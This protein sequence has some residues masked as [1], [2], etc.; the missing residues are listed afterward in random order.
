MKPSKHTVIGLMSGTSLDGL[1]LAACDFNRTNEHWS[2]SLLAAETL[3]YDTSLKTMLLEAYH[4]NDAKLADIDREFG[5][6]LGFQVNEFLRKNGLKPSLI[7]SHG[8]TVKHRPEAGI[9]YQIG[10]G[11]IL[12]NTCKITTVNNFRI[13]DVKKGGQGAPLVP[14][15]DQLLFAHYDICLNIG[16]I[17]NLSYTENG[18]RL[19]FDICP[20]NQVLNHLAAKKGQAFDAEGKI[21]ASGIIQPELLQQLN[22]LDYYHLCFPKSLGREWVD[23]SFLPMISHEQMQVQDIMCT[24]VEHIAIQ[25]A[26]AVNHLPNGKIFVTGGGALNDFLMQRIAFHCRHKVI[27]PSRE[28]IEFKEAIVFALLG[29]L[30]LQDEINCFASVTGATSD[31]STGDV[32]YPKQQL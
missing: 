10:C 19:A 9:S 3:P 12:A 21:A 30:R 1:D 11:A 25:I 15:G 6:W 20:A 27:K 5:R 29:L 31:S 24:V 16:G 13:A 4:A 22:Q 18:R 32:H 14:V 26:K 23:S 28:I 17:A 7:S 8:H 2:F